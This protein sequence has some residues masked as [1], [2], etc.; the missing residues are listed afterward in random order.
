MK[1]NPFLSQQRNLNLA[2]EELDHITKLLLRRDIMLTEANIKLEKKNRELESARQEFLRTSEYLT[3]LLAHSPDAIWVLDN[4]GRV[5]VFNRTAEE[6]TGYRSEEIM[7]R[8]IDFI[9]FEAQRYR[10]LIKLLPVQ[11]SY[12]NLRTRI[13]RNNGDLSELLISIS[14]LREEGEKGRPIGSITMSKSITREI[15]LEKALC[16]ANEK[17]EEKVRQRTSDLEV[18]SQTLMIRNQVST[19]ASQSLELD[20]LLNNILRLVLELTGFNMGAISTFEARDMIS[21]RVHVNIPEKLLERMQRLEKGDSIIGRATDDQT[22]QVARINFAEINEPGEYLV[23]AVP[24]Q[25]KGKIQGVMSLFSTLNH[26]VLGEEREM[27]L[28]IG[29]QAGWAIENAWL[30]KQVREDVV[31][32]REVDRV[33][34][35]F[36]ATISHELRTP[37]TSIIGFLRYA[38]IGIKKHDHTKLSRYIQVALE[39]GQKLAHMIE[40]LLAMQKLESNTLRLNIEP[41]VLSELLEEITEDLGPLLQAKGQELILEMPEVLPPL[42]A[43]REQLERVLTNLINNAVKFS[44]G[45][46]TITIAVHYE[47][48][49]AEFVITVKDTGIGMSQEVQDMIFER[50]Y[51]AE[52]MLTRRISG[53][54][55]GL[56][57]AKQIVEMHG[58][59]MRVESEKDKGSCFTI[60]LP[61]VSSAS[62]TTNGGD[63]HGL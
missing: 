53:V 33:K 30:Y 38:E 60:I 12:R 46:G 63:Q 18:L 59:S 42:A 23:V 25:A 37:L 49:P 21:V 55:L 16:E 1:K 34:T 5:T 57:I 40:D 8:T 2:Y 51:Q 32:L 24:L 35:D 15:R 58:G 56:T 43:D 41:V 39:N 36:I 29:V 47:A 28:A 7:G 62:Q 22:L 52:S 20:T 10:D 19:V 45:A 6:I 4:E 9:F 31:K 26:E 3:N 50:F 48:G 61:A 11:G 13:R 27:L 54:G 14:L 17:L 44:E